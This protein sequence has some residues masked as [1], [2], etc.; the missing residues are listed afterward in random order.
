MIKR[1]FFTLLCILCFLCQSGAQEL[2]YM[3]S[4]GV[5]RWKENKQ[6]IALFGAN[7]CLPS[8]CDYRA[9]DYVGG[10]REQMIAEDL[11]HFKRMNW[12]ALRLCFWGD[13]QNTDKQGNLLEN[14][15]LR[16][17]DRLVAEASKRNIYMLLSPIVTY[18]S[19]WPEMS[20]TTNT[21]LA[22][23][24]PKN[25]LIHDEQAIRAQEN[26]MKQLLNHRNPYTGRCLKDEPNILFVELINEPTQFPKDISGM[27]SYIN[28][29]CKAIRSTGC[30]KLTFYNVSQDFRVS[31]AIRKSNIQ[32]SSYA[33]YPGALNNGYSIQGNGLLFVDR[34][35]Q[36]LHPDLQGK[37]KLVYE[38]DASDTASGF[39][40]PAMVREYRR[41]GI[42]FAAVFSYDMLRTAP[43]NLGWQTHFFNMV[44]TPSK[45][46]SGMIAAE[47]MRRIP[48]GKYFGNYPDNKNFDNFRVSYEEQLS[49]L[50][51]GDMFYYSNTTTTWPK[52]P[53]ALKHI[54]GVGSSPI[55][56]YSG[57]GVYFLDKL[58]DNTWQLEI[59]PDIME[60]DEPFKMLNKNRVSRKSA[61]NE[62][63]IAIQLPGLETEMNVLP[64][65][66]LLTNGQIV[67]REELPAKDFYQTPMKDW[68][69]INHTWAE[70]A[71]DKEVTFRCEVFGPKRPE[72]VDVYLML[73]PW[74]CKR[75]SMTAEDGFCYEATVDLS[76]LA[77]GNYDYHFGIVTG[78]ESLLF[79]EGTHCTPERWDYY[80]QATYAMRLVNE[81]TPLS[82]L[83]PQDNW[84][85]IRR[86]RTFRSPEA[87]FNTVVS[88]PELQTAFQLSVPDLEKKEDYIA[89]CDV[90][91]SHYIG[92]RLAGRSLS[93]TAPT[94]IRIRAHGLTGTDKAICNFVDKEGRGYGT[95][96]SLKAEASDILI[97][98][99]DLVSTKAAMLPQDWPG[100][101]PYWYP[102]STQCYPVNA[103]DWS[104]IEFVQISLRD[105]LYDAGNQ[106]NK[107][108]VVE[109][110]DLLYRK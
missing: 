101:N 105:E 4:S 91:F 80:E 71:S 33:W 46:V 29:M 37:A 74:G 94:H 83:G 24:Y 35:E 104:C 31:P 42:Q 59:Y 67:N 38:F 30:K 49:E 63:T 50:N 22:K 68:E 108:I 3:D 36:M 10:D 78:D 90:T 96:F 77:K 81:T 5:I 98:V 1:I 16:L 34:Y 41:G 107:G 17:L 26:Y 88:G 93:K 57:T 87:Q 84:K 39:M 48:R 79:P 56:R 53:E 92:D 6:E 95:I 40:Y 18:D 89:P 28:R 75:V 20:D 106:K 99:S 85:H 11:D 102:A 2:V 9:A 25:T 19:Q 62:R 32:G 70:F 73:K 55:V 82:I 64:G 21:G 15:H 69:I 65:K 60:V 109:S 51:S 27:I 7:Y 47:V 44:Y 76:W 86:T 8:A 43:L 61:Y 97:P 103:L 58:N 45:A 110:I 52:S 23:F 13:Y 12:D 14:E 54:A 100:V 66:Y 72:Q